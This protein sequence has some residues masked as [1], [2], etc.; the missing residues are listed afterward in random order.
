[1]ELKKK[2]IVPKTPFGHLAYADFYSLKSEAD[3]PTV[4][5]FGGAISPGKYHDRE[6]S[7]PENLFAYFKAACKDISANFI[8]VPCPYGNIKDEDRPLECMKEVLKEFFM[9]SDT[10]ALSVRA[11]IGNSMGCYWSV[12][13]APWF[14]NLKT[15]ITIAGAMMNPAFNEVPRKK[16]PDFVYCFSN[17]Q[18]YLRQATLDFTR[19][20]QANNIAGSLTTRDGGHEFSDYEENGSVAEA[21][22]KSAEA[23]R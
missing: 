4:L 16:H 6:S 17:E 23:C 14:P 10:L 11:I 21:F 19:T 18:D 8:A 7:H 5:F 20:L 3:V 2:L 15:L 9:Q 13:L 12:G 1:M 22:E